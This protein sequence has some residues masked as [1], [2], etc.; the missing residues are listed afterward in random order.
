YIVGTFTG[1]VSTDDLHTILVYLETY[2]KE[3]IYYET[4]NIFGYYYRAAVGLYIGSTVDNIKTILSLIYCCCNDVSNADW[5]IGVAIDTTGDLASIQSSVYLWSNGKC[6]TIPGI[7]RTV[8]KVIFVEELLCSTSTNTTAVPDK[9][10]KRSDYKIITV[11]SRDSY[12]VLVTKCGIL[13]SDFTKYNT[14]KNLCSS[15][16]PG[17]SDIC[18]KPNSDGSYHSY[19]VQL[20]DICALIAAANRLT[21]AEID[22][23]NDGTMWGWYGYNDL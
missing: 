22:K 2:L 16:T 3:N 19:K 11:S 8:Q 12:T 7:Y 23:I 1:S 21:Q 4:S 9:L 18:L 20:G 10:S 14:E 13:A 17:L 15:L 5:I 6:A